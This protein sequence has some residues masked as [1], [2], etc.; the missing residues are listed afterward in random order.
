MYPAGQTHLAACFRVDIVIPI[1]LHHTLSLETIY[2]LVSTFLSLVAQN[3]MMLW[4][5]PT[6][7]HVPWNTCPFCWLCAYLEFSTSFPGL[8][9]GLGFI[10]DLNGAHT[11]GRVTLV[12]ITQTLGGLSRGNRIPSL[13][14]PSPSVFL[15]QDV[16][17]CREIFLGQ[18][19]DAVTGGI[20]ESDPTW[21]QCQSLFAGKR[22]PRRKIRSV[23]SETK[24]TSFSRGIFESSFLKLQRQ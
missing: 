14:T 3:V 6:Q 2:W 8:S 12:L 1:H 13:P 10:W 5:Q 21:Q 23:S 22:T 4:M 16:K 15:S 19:E 9:D 20:W 7:R 24:T 17:S 18:T 11:L